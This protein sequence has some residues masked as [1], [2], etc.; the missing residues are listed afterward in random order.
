MT[1]IKVYM[2]IRNDIQTFII[3]GVSKNINEIVLVENYI[4]LR[5]TIIH[6]IEKPIDV[7]CCCARKVLI[8]IFFFKTRSKSWNIIHIMLFRP[9]RPTIVQR[10]IFWLGWILRTI[11]SYSKR[12]LI[13]DHFLIVHCWTSL[14]NFS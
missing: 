8:F 7:F 13:S 12:K 1:P 14:N 10:N 11:L 9:I 5:K 3:L 2:Q 4:G 6:G